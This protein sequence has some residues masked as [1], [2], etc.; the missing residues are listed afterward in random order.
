MSKPKKHIVKK[1]ITK[2]LAAP[3][4][5]NQPRLD[6][7]VTNECPLLTIFN[8]V[9]GV[10]P[11]TYIFQIDKVPTFDSKTLIE[12]RV[13]ESTNSLATS[14]RIERGDELTDNTIYY[15]RVKAID[16]TGQC[17]SWGTEVGGITSRFKVDLK[18]NKRFMNLVRIPIKNII[19]PTGRGKENLTHLG[20]Y[21]DVITQWVGYKNRRVHYIQL[22]LGTQRKICRIWLL[23]EHEKMDG[24]IKDFVWEYNENGNDW[25][26]IKETQVEAS[27]GF[28]WIQDFTPIKSRYFR[29]AITRWHGSLP[30]INE[31]ELFGPGILP[32]PKVPNGDYVL[33]VGNEHDG[34]EYRDNS[35]IVSA[36]KKSGL[37]LKAFVIPYYEACPRVIKALDHPPVAVI[38]SGFSRWY[39]TLPMFEFNGEYEII[40]QEKNIPILGICGGCQFFVMAYG[41][42]FARD[43]G[44]KFFTHSVKD[45]IKKDAPSPIKILKEDPI[46]NGIPN[47]F[48]AVKFQGWEVAI[49]GSQYETLAA[50]DCIEVIKRKGRMIYGVQFHPESDTPF[51]MGRIILLNFLKMA[52][53]RFHGG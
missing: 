27:N 46:F 45:L 31:I 4:L 52:L 47:P 22:D 9:G 35:P 8:S 48:Y 53:D 5:T 30:R 17:S 1:S 32:I 29:L 33:V 16:A 15:W 23:C 3:S 39:E 18:Y 41:Y 7:I 14:K 10:T 49:V 2:T 37:N 50:S 21:D 43:I 6:T 34:R 26:A 25:T 19:T 40:R 24:R 44:K 38:L 20:G 11:R 42:T 36:I 13:P 12:Y 51:N 28:R